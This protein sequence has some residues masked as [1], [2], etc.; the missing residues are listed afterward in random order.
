MTSTS[1]KR[2]AT[3]RTTKRSQTTSSQ[4]FQ[5]LQTPYHH[6][7]QDTIQTSRAIT[8]TWTKQE[9]N[10][11][12]RSIT[13][14]STNTQL[15]L[16]GTYPSRKGSHYC[17]SRT[18]PRLGSKPRSSSFRTCGLCKTCPIWRPA[19]TSS[20][21]TP[22]ATSQKRAAY[23]SQGMSPPAPIRSSK[24]SGCSIRCSIRC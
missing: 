10:C 20:P 4:G 9:R 3:P 19:N 12:N 24:T 21:C 16:R 23:T 8:T 11:R 15:K 13:I 1:A 5:L 18:L 14:S 22:R 2:C 17:C 6:R 7:C